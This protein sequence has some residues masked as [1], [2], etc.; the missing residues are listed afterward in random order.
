MI[1]LSLAEAQLF[2]LLVSLFGTDQVLP[3]LSVMGICGGELPSLPKVNSITNDDLAIWARNNKCLFT[4]VDRNDNPKIVLEFFAGFEDSIDTIEEEHVRIL[5][6]LFG[7]YGIHYITMSKD[8]FND[9]LDPGNAFDLVA[10]LRA[11]LGHE[12]E[13]SHSL[14]WASGRDNPQDID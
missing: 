12:D 7:T 2:R 1:A 14:T 4:V 11:K 13:N 3:H 10:F 5:P 6:P 8:E 9:I